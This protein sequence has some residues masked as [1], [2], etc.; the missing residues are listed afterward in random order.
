MSS[1]FRRR[2]RHVDG[3]GGSSSIL[4]T[5]TQ[6]SVEQAVWPP[7]S[8]R[9]SFNATPPA[10][11]IRLLG[12]LMVG[13]GFID[14]NRVDGFGQA[15]PPRRSAQLPN[16]RRFALSSGA[17]RRLRLCAAFSSAF[18]MLSSIAHNVTPGHREEDQT[19]RAL[20]VPEV[21]PVASRAFKR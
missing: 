19:T 12:R 20:G 21:A 17:L 14:R 18:P 6:S 2:P 4:F 8:G 5:K 11:H 3:A 7:K 13:R 10:F 1:A 15:S 16:T 9:P